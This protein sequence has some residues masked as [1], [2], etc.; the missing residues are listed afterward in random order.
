MSK[1]LKRFYELWLASMLSRLSDSEK[2]HVD[3]GEPS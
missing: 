2:V 3:L 1:M